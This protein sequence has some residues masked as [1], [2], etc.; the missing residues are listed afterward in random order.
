MCKFFNSYEESLHL[1]VCKLANYVRSCIVFWKNL[2]SWQKFYTTSGRGG[3]NKFQVCEEVI[4]SSWYDNDNDN[5]IWYDMDQS[6]DQSDILTGKLLLRQHLCQNFDQFPF[7]YQWNSIFCNSLFDQSHL[8]Y[9][10]RDRFQKTTRC[11][12]F[13]FCFNSYLMIPRPQWWYPYPISIFCNFTC[14]FQVNT[15]QRCPNIFLSN[16]VFHKCRNVIKFIK[17]NI[18]DVVK[19]CL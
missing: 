12:L 16:R 14:A 13:F 8:I 17:S 1:G 11:V 5:V 3:R 15:Y 7:W 9:K 4:W 10:T 18:I 19:N 2:H 6:W